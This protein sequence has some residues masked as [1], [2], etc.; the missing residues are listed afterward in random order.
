MKVLDGPRRAFEDDV[1]CLLS[2]VKL[3]IGKKIV[4]TVVV[5]QCW[6]K[7]IIQL[8]GPDQSKRWLPRHRHLSLLPISEPEGQ[9]HVA[10]QSCVP[11]SEKTT[12]SRQLVKMYRC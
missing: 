8:L 7:S 9:L 10:I 2:P 4:E 3:G 6:R 5:H 12:E 11:G 1:M